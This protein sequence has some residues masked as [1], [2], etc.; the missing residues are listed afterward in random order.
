MYHLHSCI[1]FC[2]FAKCLL[3]C[4]KCKHNL[5]NFNDEVNNENSI[6][7]IRKNGFT[8]ALPA[9]LVLTDVPEE[10]NPRSLLRQFVL[11]QYVS[12]AQTI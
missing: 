9:L 4:K 8:D 10:L 11:P 6:D 1:F 12:R 2:T 7:R 3:C 5:L